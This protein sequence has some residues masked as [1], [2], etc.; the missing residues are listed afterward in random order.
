LYTTQPKFY[1]G[2]DLHVAWM[3]V[4][5]I[6]ADG[7]GRVHKNIRTD[8]QAFLQPL[9]P[10]REDVVVCVECMF[11]WSWRAERCEDEG[12]PFVL[13]HALYMRAMHGGTAKNDRIDAHKSAALW[14]GG[15]LPQ[16]DVDPRRMRATRDLRRRSQHRMHTRAE[17]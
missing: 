11:P 6:D 17:L 2:I 15:L 5:V 9:K 8:P 10:F 4:C 3:Y 13:G 16:A 14:R 7:E 12:I 1:C